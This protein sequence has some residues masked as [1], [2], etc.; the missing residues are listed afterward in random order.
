MTDRETA[1]ER[2]AEAGYFVDV[3]D[4]YAGTKDN[5][6]EEKIALELMLDSVTALVGGFTTPR[7][8]LGALLRII[9]ATS[10]RESS[11]YRLLG[12]PS[13]LRSCFGYAKRELQV[14]G[15]APDD[16]I[17]VFEDEENGA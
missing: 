1:A 12:P 4:V 8:A 3:W 2:A 11:S 16:L 13:H 14:T 10:Y 9:R 5:S 17:A 15:A 6:P 7:E